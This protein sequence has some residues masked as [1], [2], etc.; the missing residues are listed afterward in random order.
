MSFI[1]LFFAKQIYQR[2]EQVIYLLNSRWHGTTEKRMK[3]CYAIHRVIES[4]NGRMAWT[5]RGFRDD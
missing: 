1:C 2:K 5:G 3:H 4:N